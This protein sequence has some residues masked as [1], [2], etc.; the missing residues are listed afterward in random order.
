MAFFVYIV[1]NRPKGTLYI[2]VTNNLARR[3]GEHKSSHHEGFTKRYKL[4]LLVWFAAHDRVVNAIAHEKR[5]KRWNR[6]WKID[7][8]EA[9]NPGWEDLTPPFQ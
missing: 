8:I 9:S 2:G 3:V 6:A 4:G 7:L 5:L 1:T